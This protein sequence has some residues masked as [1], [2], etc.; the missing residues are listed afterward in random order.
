[1]RVSTNIKTVDAFKIK[2][3]V[4]QQT[5]SC[6]IQQII[7]ENFLFI[8]LFPI[9]TS[10]VLGL[11]TSILQLGKEYYRSQF[12]GGGV[13]DSTS[14]T[15]YCVLIIWFS[16]LVRCNKQ[17]D[18][19]I[20][21]YPVQPKKQQIDANLALLFSAPDRTQKPYPSRCGPT[22]N[23]ES[24]PHARTNQGWSIPEESKSTD[25]D[26]EDALIKCVLV[27]LILILYEFLM[28]NPWLQHHYFA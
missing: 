3:D 4:Y 16:R 27:L 23:L 14:Y 18:L 25:A 26:E 11:G 24:V 1:M 21:P 19:K 28:W 10:Q 2:D 12:R 7:K 20:N 5:W 8:F 22:Y 9:Q 17:A 13:N 6:L 15:L